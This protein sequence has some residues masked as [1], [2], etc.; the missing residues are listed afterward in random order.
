MKAQAYYDDPKDMFIRIF[1]TG[2]QY[3]MADLPLN[4][5]TPDAADHAL[6]QMRLRR[7]SRWESADWGRE[8]RV[9]FR[10]SNVTNEARDA[11]A[12]KD[13]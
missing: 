4:A 11:R 2:G 5:A 1:P 13:A 6:R 7:C 12:G 9:C 3:G 10:T 8:A